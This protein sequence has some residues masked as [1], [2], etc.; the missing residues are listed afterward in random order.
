MLHPLHEL[1]AGA[2]Q[3]AKGRYDKRIIVKRRDEIGEFA[4]FNYASNKVSNMKF[5]R[6]TLGYYRLPDPEHKD[7]YTYVPAWRLWSNSGDASSFV[8]NAM[9]GSV[10]NDWTEKRKVTAKTD[11]K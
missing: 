5:N 10:V 7:L 2:R 11:P 8:V 6:L 1:S 9:D 3:I 4:E